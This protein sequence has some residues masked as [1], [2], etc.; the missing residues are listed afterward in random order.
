M[1]A[2]RLITAG[3]S[4]GPALL[5]I[6]DGFPAGIPLAQEM[7]NRELARR[8]AGYGRG[9]R[10]THTVDWARLQAGV[11]KGLTTGAPIGMEISNPEPHAG[12]GPVP[13]RATP[14]PV[15][16]PG[17]ADL[18]AA[19]KY[20]TAD[21]WPYVER[22]SAR[23]TASR[24]AGAA[25]AKA[26]LVA[27][28]IRTGCHVTGIGPVQT[29]HHL[30]DGAGSLG[31]AEWVSILDRAEDDP[32]RAA[33]PAVSGRMRGAIDEASTSGDTLGGTFEVVAL[34][35]P[36]GLGTFA[37]WD[38]RLDARLAA[39]VMSVPGV[40]AVVLGSGLALASLPGSAAHDGVIPGDGPFGTARAANLAGGIEG[41]ITNGQPIFVCGAMKPIPSLR[42]S[43][44]SVDL[45][46]G[47]VAPAPR[48]RGDVCAVPAAAVVAEAMLAW[49]LAA[50]AMDRFGGDTLAAL[51]AAARK[52]GAP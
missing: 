48:V 39:A 42:G 50:A 40:R 44:P 14:A 10:A 41:G 26:L 34:G 30:Q 46:T 13:D 31:A 17:H 35:C 47:S 8:Q 29:D 18:P 3:E 20:G 7:V 2:P 19:L 28:G 43:L 45:A 36:P 21:F 49:E 25:V 24:V 23:E 27:L 37:Q 38:R 12:P 11:S 51:Q 5:V 52:A 33:N 15:P 22:A 4:H 16:R 1:A 32:L 6:V 9:P